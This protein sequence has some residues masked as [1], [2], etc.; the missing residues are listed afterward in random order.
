MLGIFQDFFIPRV[1]NIRPDGIVHKGMCFARHKSSH[2]NFRVDQ[3]C[4]TF[5]GSYLHESLTSCTFL[6]GISRILETKKLR[7]ISYQRWTTSLYSSFNHIPKKIRRKQ[8]YTSINVIGADYNGDLLSKNFC[9]RSGKPSKRHQ[10][11]A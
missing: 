8:P 6:H 9:K 1:E 7:A 10:D 4:R 11:P 5:L 3:K 2:H